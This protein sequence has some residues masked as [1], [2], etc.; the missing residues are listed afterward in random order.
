VAAL[1]IVLFNGV[2]LCAYVGGKRA[3][4]KWLAY[5][6]LA[7]IIQT[8]LCTLASGVMLGTAPSPNSIEGQAC[9]GPQQNAAGMNTVCNL[10]VCILTILGRGQ[11][12]IVLELYSVYDACAVLDGDGDICM[13]CGCGK[14]AEKAVQTEVRKAQH[15]CNN[16]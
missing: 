6:G 2:A 4:E 3:V 13:G 16:C 8:T 15:E 1:I 7:N 10:Q 14:T 9:N 11:M 5:E 12:V